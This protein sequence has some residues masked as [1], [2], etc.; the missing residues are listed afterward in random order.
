MARRS[1][2]VIDANV[3]VDYQATDLA[4]LALVDRH[5]GTVHILTTM[6]AEVEGFDESHDPGGVSEEV[7][8]YGLKGRAS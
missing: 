1:F 5:V 2:L 4:I 8:Q 7:G 3:L 6:L